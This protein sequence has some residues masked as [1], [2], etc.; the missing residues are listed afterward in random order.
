MWAVAIRAPLRLAR[1]ALAGVLAL[2]LLDTS[3]NGLFVLASERGYLSIVAVLGS[4]YPVATIIA[5]TCSCA[6]TS[7]RSSTRGSPSRSSGSRSSPQA[8][9]RGYAI[10]PIL[11]SAQDVGEEPALRDERHAVQLLPR[12]RAAAVLERQGSGRVVEV[13]TASQRWAA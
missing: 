3:A 9:A 12:R 2:G 4:L 10:H 6:S 5:V 1:S 11:V 7:A 8:G 13:S